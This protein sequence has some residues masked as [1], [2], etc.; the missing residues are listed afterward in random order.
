MR[1]TRDSRDC[2]AFGVRRAPPSVPGRTPNPAGTVNANGRWLKQARKLSQHKR[3]TIVKRLRADTPVY[4]IAREL[5]IPRRLVAAVKIALKSRETKDATDVPEDS[6]LPRRPGRPPRPR[7]E[8]NAPPEYDPSAVA[9]ATS[10]SALAADPAP[11]TRTPVS[12]ERA[13]EKL[14][15]LIRARIP[16]EKR[17]EV[18]AKLLE[19]DKDSVRMAAL[20]AINEID[21]IIPKRGGVLEGDGADMPTALFLLPKGTTAPNTQPP[22]AMTAASAPIIASPT[23][24]T[25]S[26]PVESA[27]DRASG[28]PPSNDDD[29]RDLDTAANPSAVV[30]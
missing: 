26:K 20:N 22:A 9:A 8:P 7:P 16:L 27:A 18:L 2:S 1:C 29:A 3:L 24:P 10:P 12:V 5:A 25:D 28:D 21:G 30:A 15:R 17:V 23:E 13:R 14:R 19:S 11:K 4:L 6:A